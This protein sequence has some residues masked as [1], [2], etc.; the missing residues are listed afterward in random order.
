MM[1]RDRLQAAYELAFYPPRL[2]QVWRKVKNREVDDADELIELLE[3]AMTL[4]R[5]LPQ[6]GYS[7]MSA[8]KR[9]A[10]YQACS[11]AF[12]AVRFL[13]NVYRHLTGG[14]E[15]QLPDEVPGEWVRD[16]AL[17]DFNHHARRSEEPDRGI[18]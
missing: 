7:S 18:H 2:D 15:P 9:L 14:N 5:V 6:E 16:F 8:L 17:P 10:H 11:R 13:H 4:H 12:G 1:T 3:M